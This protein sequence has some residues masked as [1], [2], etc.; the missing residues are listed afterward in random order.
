M[1]LKFDKENKI[2]SISMSNG[3]KIEL[4]PQYVK[5]LVNLLDKNQ[6]II[7]DEENDDN[8]SL[9]IVWNPRSRRHEPKKKQ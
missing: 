7:L 1:E 3:T 6:K 4:P 2:L 5:E 8:S 9:E